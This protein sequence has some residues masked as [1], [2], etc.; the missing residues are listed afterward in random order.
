MSAQD[1]L[2]NRLGRGR[3][4]FNRHGRLLEDIIENGSTTNRVR[5]KNHKLIYWF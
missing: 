3:V 1:N 2:G 5:C 4:S